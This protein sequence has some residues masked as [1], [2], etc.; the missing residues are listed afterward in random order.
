MFGVNMP[1]DPNLGTVFV[2]AIGQTSGITALAST[3]EQAALFVTPSSGPPGTTFKVKG[4]GFGSFDQVTVWFN[5]VVVATRPAN[6]QGA[7]T[8]TLKVPPAT[9]TGVYTVGAH[10]QFSQVG[11]NTAFTVPP[12]VSINPTSGPSGTQIT[13]TGSKFT[14]S[15]VVD[16]DWYDPNFGGLSFLLSVT[17]SSTGTFTATVTAPSNLVSGNVYAIEVRDSSGAFGQAPF[18]A[19]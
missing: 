6:A 4:G 1:S 10:G 13:V 17:A 9:A 14:R 19:Q 12:F 3:P 15:C 5:G 7:F 2:A 11:V 8:A 16:I 18:T